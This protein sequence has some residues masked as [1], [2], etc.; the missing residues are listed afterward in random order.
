MVND[1]ARPDDAPELL[2]FE[3]DSVPAADATVTVY[4]RPGCMFCTSL[5]GG[6]ERAGLAFERRDIWEDETAAAFVR[7]VADGN[8]TVPTVTVG[9]LA[10]VNPTARDV[11]RAV[12]D[13][14]PDA[15]PE[16]ARTELA[17]GQGRVGQVL[18][19]IFGDA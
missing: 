3:D 9:D 11:L 7:S 12:A 1:D 16:T 5:L 4:W 6:L 19:R 13:R 2:R 14:D 18:G 17:R 10:L 8:E 15:L